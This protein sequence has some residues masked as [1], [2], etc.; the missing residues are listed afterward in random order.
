MLRVRWLGRVEYREAHDLQR[1]LFKASQDDHL[2][3]LEHEHVF[4]GGPHADIS[5]LLTSPSALG[6]TYEQTDR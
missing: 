1:R 6:S 5:N 2:L 3:L 4:T